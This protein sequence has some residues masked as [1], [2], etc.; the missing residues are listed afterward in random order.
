MCQAY[1]SERMIVC[2]FEKN[3]RKRGY[4]AFNAGV[5]ECPQD[6]WLPVDWRLGYNIAKEGGI[7]F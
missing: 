5:K 6:E 4:D 3:A 7:L 1:E 2:V